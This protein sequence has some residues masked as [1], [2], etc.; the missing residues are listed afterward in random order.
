M[1]IRV[2]LVDDSPVYIAAATALLDGEGLTVVGSAADA[3]QAVDLCDRLTPDVVLVDIGLGDESGFDVVR[4]LARPGG[5]TL[6]LISTRD[7]DEI[8]EL[9]QDSPAS[10]FVAKSAISADAIRGLMP[11]ED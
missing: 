4:R 10:G 2:A 5:P 8:D 11:S 9:L 3:A 1:Q 7:V 6:I